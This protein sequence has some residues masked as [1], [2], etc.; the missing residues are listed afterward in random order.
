MRTPYADNTVGP[1]PHGPAHRRDRPYGS[2][3]PFHVDTA[4]E[5]FHAAIALS[6]DHHAL[7]NSRAEWIVRQLRGSFEVLDHFTMGSIPKYTALSGHADLDVLVVL[8]FG[9]HI[10]GKCPGRVLIDVRKALGPRAGS[11]RRNGQAVTVTFDSWPNVDVV[12]ASR[13]MADKATGKVKH[14]RIPD[15]HRGE[16]LVTK[17][18]RHT[19]NIKARASL[20]G[21]EFRRV[22]RMVKDWNRRQAVRLQSYHVEVIALQVLDSYD[23]YSWAVY[24]WFEVAQDHLDICIYEGHDVAAYLTDDQRNAIDDQL[25]GAGKTASDA[26]Y[27]TCD[28]NDDHEL[29]IKLWKSIFGQRFPDCGG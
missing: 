16:W 18:R 1:S 19:R 2:C 26:W 17:P 20:E 22:V 9:K 11:P 15:M 5:E 8:H 24:R 3:V 23:D 28:T 27:A 12:P 21:P 7:A 4:F 25:R 29:A 6:G 10:K 13:T 14:Y